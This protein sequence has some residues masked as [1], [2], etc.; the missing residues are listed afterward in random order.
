MTVQT[1][2]VTRTIWVIDPAHT[3]VEFGVRHMMVSTVKGRFRDV[4][5]AIELDETD[6][7]R[8]SVSVEIDVA[9]IDTGEPQRDAHLRSAD[10]FDA[11]RYPVITF[12]S[13]RIEEA[14]HDR[15]R[16]VGDLTIRDVTREV[17]LDATYEGRAR[18][19]YGNERIGFSAR[20]TLNR[21]DFGL[22][23]NVALET[24]GF[25]VGDTVTVSAE[26][27]AIKQE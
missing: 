6:P 18:D 7:T 20:T 8:S 22:T 11:E 21:R 25:I 10:F 9:S 2:P 16:V 27:E 15:Y 12:Q 13:R 23:W 3:L 19:P 1:R 24:G 26:V 14:G 17:T 4:R 5:G